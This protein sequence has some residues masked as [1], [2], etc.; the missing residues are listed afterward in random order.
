MGTADLCG[1]SRPRLSRA[2][3]P[4]SLI[5]KLPV[6]VGHS[7]SDASDFDFDFGFDF[8]LLLTLTLPPTFYAAPCRHS[9]SEAFT[10][11]LSRQLKCRQLRR[12]Q[13][14]ID[15]RL[16]QCYLSRV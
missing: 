4:S 16:D 12:A 9:I 14:G 15:Y 2:E 8:D 5:L 3:G 7:L 11:Q 1:D 13:F 6:S 10:S